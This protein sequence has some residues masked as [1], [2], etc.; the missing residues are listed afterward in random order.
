MADVPM[1]GSLV[2]STR[3]DPDFFALYALQRG[4]HDVFVYD[5]VFQGMATIVQRDVNLCR[6]GDNMVVRHDV[7]R[8]V[9]DHTRTLTAGIG[10]QALES[11][12]DFAALAAD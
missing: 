4:T 8:L 9:D 7:S 12:I 5:D 3:R 1:H 2:L 6:V 10:M 11:R